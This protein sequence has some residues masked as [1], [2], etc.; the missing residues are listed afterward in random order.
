MGMKT[1]DPA[2]RRRGRN[3]ELMP[4]PLPGVP[5]RL[6]PRVPE[7]YSG[8]CSTRD[9]RDAAVP[10]GDHWNKPRFEGEPNSVPRLGKGQRRRSTPDRGRITDDLPAPLRFQ[11]L[12]T[13]VTYELLH[14]LLIP[15]DRNQSYSKKR[16]F[17]FFSKKCCL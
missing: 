13:A 4:L 5:A 2:F 6:P 7:V 12:P 14:P 10:S 9:P 8:E 16:D 1:V 15:T 11:S 3:T 17:F